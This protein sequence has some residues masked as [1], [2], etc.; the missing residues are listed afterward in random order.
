LREIGKNCGAQ[1]IMFGECLHLEVEG[2]GRGFCVCEGGRGRR[3]KRRRRRGRGGRGEVIMEVVAVTAA[4]TC[5]YLIYAGH[6]AKSFTTLS[7]TDP[8]NKT[9]LLLLVLYI[10]FTR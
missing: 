8:I 7:H 5:T 6:Y 2:R 1:T 9:L 10:N 4:N 3:R